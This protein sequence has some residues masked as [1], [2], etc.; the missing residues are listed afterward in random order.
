MGCSAVFLAP[1]LVRVLTVTMYYENAVFGLVWTGSIILDSYK[2]WL[3]RLVGSARKVLIQYYSLTCDSHDRAFK[4]V[5][6]IYNEMEC[7]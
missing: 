6:P 3:S 5:H 7:D 4:D 1:V 2:T